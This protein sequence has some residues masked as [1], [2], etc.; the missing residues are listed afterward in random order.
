M[1]DNWIWLLVGILAGALAVFWGLKESAKE[2]T[3]APAKP[4][5]TVPAK[6]LLEEPFK[7]AEN[8]PV[9]IVEFADFRCGYCGRHAAQTLPLIV[10]EYIDAGK[11]RYI[12]RNFAFLGVESRWAAEA[13]ECA[14]EQGAFWQYH[15]RLYQLQAQGEKFLRARLK[16]VATELG[17]QQE[18]FD[19]CL[20]QSEYSA[21]VDEDIAA[22]RSAGV[23][24]T[25]SFLI[26]G[27]LLVGAHPIETFRQKIDEALA[28]AQK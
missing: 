26:D 2:P 24:G 7:G 20:E 4:A 3:P 18:K 16:A 12:F 6:T 21:E 15:D 11:V 22:G 5:P 9:T 23:T 25:P 14:H 10:R 27:Q 28:K 1:K 19:A 13:A 17:L 8:A